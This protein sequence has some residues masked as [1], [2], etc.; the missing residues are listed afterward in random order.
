MNSPQGLEYRRAYLDAIQQKQFELAYYAHT[1]LA[2]TDELFPFELDAFYDK[3]GKRKKDE[4]DARE[5]ALKERSKQSSANH[6]P[7]PP[8]RRR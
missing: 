2:D 1:S 3:L 8:R 7:K 4:A 5:A 6:K